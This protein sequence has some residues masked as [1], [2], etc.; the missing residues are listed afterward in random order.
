MTLSAPLFPSLGG[1]GGIQGHGAKM[2]G[3]RRQKERED[4]KKE[5]DRT[6]TFDVKFVLSLL[7]LQTLMLLG[8]LSV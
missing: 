7:V 8:S 6:L 5:R 1:V 3:E 4:E 2:H